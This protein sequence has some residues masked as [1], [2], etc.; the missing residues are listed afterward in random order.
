[1]LA[2]RPCSERDVRQR[3]ARRK[4]QPALIEDTVRKLHATRLLDDAAYARSWTESRDRI[5]P[6]GRRLLV[7]ELRAHGVA[8]AVAATAVADVSDADAAYRVAGRKMR[9]LAAL[10][11]QTFRNRLGSLL[12]RRGFGWEICKT[13]VERCW[14][15]LG[16]E[17]AEAAGDD[18]ELP[19]G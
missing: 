5:S 14:R 12:Q 10:D 15:E 7:Q 9:S 13:T 19:V 17:G 6:R 18:F 8:A 16:P 4:F 2:R 1:M 3:L 11:Y